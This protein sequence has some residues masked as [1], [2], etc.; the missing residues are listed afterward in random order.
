MV[1]IL[2]NGSYGS[3]R[4]NKEVLDSLFNLDKREKVKYFD[5]DYRTNSQLIEIFKEKGSEYLS[6]K[7]CKLYLETIPELYYKYDA[8]HIDVYDGKETLYLNPDLLKYMLLIE[9]FK[10]FN[11]DVYDKAE[12]RIK[13]IINNI[14]Y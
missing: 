10:N 9:E 6:G 5:E 1:E 13:D 3:F 2:L 14:K 11:R 8:Y 7:N 12:Q 4:F